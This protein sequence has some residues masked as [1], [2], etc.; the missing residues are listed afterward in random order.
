MPVLDK[1]NQAMVEKYQNFILNSP[2]SKLSQDMRWEKVKNTWDSDY[3]YLEDPQT[4]EITA[5][6]SILS[7]KAV[8]GKRLM[9]ANRG[10]VCDFYD[11]DTVSK[12][13]DEAL[14]VAQKNNAFVLRID[15]E[16]YYDQSL[17]DQYK[18]KGFTFRGRETNIHSFTQPHYNMIMDI[19]SG[20]EEKILS[21]FHSKTR[22]NI[23]L[24]KRKG[25]QTRWGRSQE[26]IDIFHALTKIMAERQG[27]TYRPKEYFERMIA[28]YPEI[29]IY[30]SE[31]ENIPLSAAVAFP[32]NDKMWYLYGASSNEMR[33]KMPNYDMQWSMIK[34][35]IELK[36]HFYDFGG[37]FTL[38]N[39][40]GLF[41]FKSGFCGETPVTEWIG[42]L[43]HVYD[44]EAYHKFINR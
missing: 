11:I 30:I 7:I 9:Y 14:P 29:R 42:E 22:Y 13:I 31:F 3:V 39:T 25:I 12:L 20:D 23:R 35:A 26:E 33:N 15:P 16:V 17:I 40:D 34:W 5:A 27:I 43:D 4:K 28:A 32:Y 24:A 36:K 10:P 44:Q 19:S 21:S 37:V 1:N 41:A 18:Q 2:Y 38:D 8:D 6:L